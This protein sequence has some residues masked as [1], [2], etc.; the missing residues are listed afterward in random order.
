MFPV[1]LYMKRTYRVPRS[2]RGCGRGLHHAVRVTVV[3]IEHADTVGVG[4]ARRAR[5]EGP[6]EHVVHPTHG[7]AAAA[8]RLLTAVVPQGDLVTTL[9]VAR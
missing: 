9:K 5:L 7:D 8:G 6:P 2:R 3:V 1:V 4:G